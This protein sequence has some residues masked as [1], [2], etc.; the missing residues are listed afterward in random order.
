[1]REARAAL[2]AGQRQPHPQ[3]KAPQAP[4]RSR[5]LQIIINSLQLQPQLIREDT[6]SATH[7]HSRAATTAAL[8][9]EWHLKWLPDP[10]DA[11]ASPRVPIMELHREVVA[12]FPVE[13]N[14]VAVN[15][16]KEYKE[17]QRV[18]KERGG[19]RQ[20]SEHFRCQ[21]FQL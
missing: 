19:M 11:A 15:I 20:S 17:V 12:G 3:R 13:L 4:M 10:M 16:G 1:M 18:L 21:S 8:I 9:L 6:A 5:H 2:A 14:P 7:H